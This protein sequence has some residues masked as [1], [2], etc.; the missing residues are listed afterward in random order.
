MSLQIALLIHSTW[1]LSP[2]RLFK[3]LKHFLAFFSLICPNP[4]ADQAPA[5]LVTLVLPTGQ[6]A[7]PHQQQMRH[8]PNSWQRAG[9]CLKNDVPWRRQRGSDIDT[10]PKGGVPVVFSAR[11]LGADP[12]RSVGCKVEPKW[13]LHCLCSCHN[14]PERWCG[15][16]RCPADGD[17]CH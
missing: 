16:P 7:L 6:C 4:L 8:L 17:P 10:W 14:I 13:D 15:R 1:I 12:L 3:C 5:H 11:V 9:T 2:A